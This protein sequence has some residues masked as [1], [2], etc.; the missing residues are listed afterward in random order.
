M[1]LIDWSCNLGPEQAY[2][3]GDNLSNDIPRARRREWPFLPAG[4]APGLMLCTNEPLRTL[5]AA[6]D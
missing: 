4:T 1:F 3:D 2:L 5:S 6:G